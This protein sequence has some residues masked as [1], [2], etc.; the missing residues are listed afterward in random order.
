[1]NIKI[2][3]AKPKVN[4]EKEG[5]LKSNSTLKGCKQDFGASAREFAKRSKITEVEMVQ[6]NVA[7][8]E[9]KK[10]KVESSKLESLTTKGHGLGFTQDLRDALVIRDKSERAFEYLFVNKG[11][12]IFRPTI[13]PIGRSLRGL[14]KR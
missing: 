9:V 7:A 13:P 12:A 4:V 10:S 2:V 1:M 6:I 5:A 11:F 8:I 14:P 3:K